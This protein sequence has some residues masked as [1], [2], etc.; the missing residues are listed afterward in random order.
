[1]LTRREV[2]KLGL[3]GGAS[4]FAPAL[5]ARAQA[6]P[7]PLPIPRTLSPIRSDST[8]DYYVLTMKQ[9]E[10]EILPGAKTTIWGY[11]GEFP[12]PTI[13]ARS[14]RNVVVR[15]T[16][17]LPEPMSVHLHGGHVAPDSDGHPTDLIPP[18][19]FKDYLYPN[20]QDA[21]TLWYHDHAMDATAPHVYRGLA[22]MY[23]IEDD[24]ESDLPLPKGD[25][26]VPLVIQDR[27]F[28]S[29]GSLDYTLTSQGMMGGMGGGMMGGMGGGMMGGMGGMMGDRVFL[30]NTV[31]VN[32][33]V[34]PYFEVATRRYRFRLL[35][36]S[37]ARE[38]SLALDSGR[39]FVQV[40]TEGGLLPA[41][42]NRSWVLLAPGERVD[43]VVDFSHYEPG[44]RVVLLNRLAS[45]S[46][47]AVM[48]FD[49]VRREA[50]ES[51]VPGTLRPIERLSP[52]SASAVRR[53]TLMQGPNG[54]WGMNGA[55]FD[56]ARIDARPRLGETEMW[57]FFNMSMMAHPVHIHDV[58]WQVLD[59]NGAPPSPGEAGWKDT[60]RVPP[61]MGRVRAIA[62][63]TDYAGPYVFHCHVLEHE[64]RGLMGQFEVV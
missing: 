33:A 41:P 44:E 1:M 14:G 31:L 53:F 32:G 26:D 3:L 6:A 22:G 42:V 13:R 2:I 21:C 20:S 60:F 27:S 7:R 59:T 62:R 34:Q 30:G 48:R 23:I 46:L 43:V 15:Q 25:Y 35:N 5:P 16:N 49:V 37:N 9:A 40:G 47:R 51:S 19:A 61:M 38:Y 29:D 45:G 12:G 10:V 4:L 57:E 18:G 64:D 56:P 54:A 63:F 17:E 11:D 36:G 52:A 39:P 28:N 24:F 50:D 58:R 8:T 55:P